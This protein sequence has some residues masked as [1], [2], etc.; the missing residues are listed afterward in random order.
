M[1]SVWRNLGIVAGWLLILAG[2]AWWLIALVR[3]VRHRDRDTTVLR[4][5]FDK[6]YDVEPFGVRMAVGLALVIAGA[7]AVTRL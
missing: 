2:V 4:A 7:A 5:L 3:L 1:L 6:Q